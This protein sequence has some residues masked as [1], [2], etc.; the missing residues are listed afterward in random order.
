MN[1][2]ITLYE[3]QRRIK[4]VL[5][6]SFSEDVWVRCEIHEI[7]SNSTNSHC[8]LNLA[9]KGEDGAFFKAKCSAI[10]WASRWKI[11]SP[12]FEEATGQKLSAG[13]SVLLQ[14]KVQYSEQYG[15]SLIVINIDPA[16]TLGEIE[17]QRQRT[18]ERLKNEGLM[19]MNSSLSLPQLPRRFALI[20]ASK[21]AGYGDFM[22]HLH[23]NPY[24]F[25][26]YT[27]LYSAPMQGDSAPGGIIEQLDNIWGDVQ[28]GDHFD[29]V[30]ILR[31]GGAVSDLICF[32]DYELAAHI[33]Q[34]PLP[35]LCAVGHERDF[36]IC[37]MVSAI[38]VKTPT[39]LADYVVDIFVAEDAKLLS[40]ATRVSVAVGNK[41]KG[42]SLLLQN[43]QSRILRAIQSKY[44]REYNLLNMLELRI[45]RGNPLS[46]L[47]SGYT[48]VLG[49]KGKVLS[50]EDVEVG[51]PLQVVFKDGIA[52]CNVSDVKK[53]KMI[54]YE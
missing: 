46:H 17:L 3:L 20:S 28:R 40:L 41:V 32:D 26:F 18:I 35:V 30:M 13:M 38:S 22:D 50:I 31:G 24:G 39:A 44:D 37:D 11:L 27:K 8:Y 36:H 47:E 42:A 52:E 54:D 43:Y 16:F 33:A 45:K 53:Q 23:N 29:A 2:G 34:F 51:G 15:L 1:K 21:A 12:F 6:D 14:V 49:Q 7:H 25:S 4:G 5:E 10:I 9:D 19:D 48:L